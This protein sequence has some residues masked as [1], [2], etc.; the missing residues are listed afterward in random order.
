MPVSGGAAQAAN[1]GQIDAYIS[2]ILPD[3]SNLVYSTL[4]GGGDIEKSASIAVDAVGNAVVGG[5]TLSSNFPAV[6][7]FQN[8]LPGFQAGFVTKVNSTGTAF[9]FST[10]L[11]GRKAD[12]VNAVAVEPTT[13]NVYAGGWTTS[14]NFPTVVPVQGQKRGTKA[15]IQSS[16]DGGLTWSENDTGINTQSA[17][18]LAINRNTPTSL[19]ASAD[20]SNIYRSVN[21]GGTWA[22]TVT[23]GSCGQVTV[24]P[25]KANANLLYAFGSLCTSSSMVKSTDGGASWGSAGAAPGVISRAM[26]VSPNNDSTL[27]AVDINSAVRKGTNGGATWT[28][29]SFNLPVATIYSIAIDSTGPQANIYL[30]GT[31]VVYKMAENGT[32]WTPISLGIDPN[33]YI[34]VIRTDPAGNAYALAGGV[35]TTLYKL[36]AGTNTWVTVYSGF[37][38]TPKSMAIAPSNSNVMYVG[39]GANGLGALFATT[40]GGA[41][42]S[43]RPSDFDPADIQ[44]H[45]T[46]PNTVHVATSLYLRTDGFITKIAAAGGSPLL[47][48]T[49]FGSASGG[50]VADEQ[51]NGLVTPATAGLVYATGDTNRLGFPITVGKQL[52]AQTA[53]VAKLSD[54]TPACSLTFAPSEGFFYPGGGTVTVSIVAPSACN[55]TAVSNAPWVTFSGPA[56]GTGIGQVTLVVGANPGAER[57][58]TI[59]FAATGQTIPVIQAASGCTYA[60]GTVAPVAVG[61]GPISIPL[62]TGAGCSWR[63][64]PSVTWLTMTSPTGGTGPTTFQV[65]VAPNPNIKLR[66]GYIY[67]GSDFATVLQS[68]S[69]TFGLSPASAS[70]GAQLTESTI[71][72]TASGGTC[73]WSAMSLTD[74]LSITSGSAGVGNGTVA[75]AAEQNTTGS[76]RSGS[77]QIGDKFFPVTQGECAFYVSPVSAGAPGAG[78][79][80][81]I[82]ISARANCGWT[83]VSNDVWITINSGSAGTGNGTVTYTVTPNL[84]ASPRTGSIT[85]AGQTFTIVQAAAGC[86]YSIAG[87]PAQGTAIGGT[88][89]FVLTSVPG[90]TWT[91]SSS[92]S[93][94]TITSATAG[95]GGTTVN[96]SYPANSALTIRTATI[97]IMGAPYTLIQNGVRT[98][99][100]QVPTAT[101][102]DN[103][104]G[105]RIMRVGDS[106]TTSLGGSFASDTVSAHVPGTSDTWTAVRLAGGGLYTNFY[107]SGGA[108]TWIGIG[109]VFLG[110][111]SIT[112]A[113]DGTAWVV[114]RDIFK[115]IWIYKVDTALGA[116]PGIFLGGIVES[117]PSAIVGPDG[118]LHIVGRDSWDGVWVV[119]FDTK[120]NSV[121]GWTFLGGIISGNPVATLGADN[122]VY[123]AV[124]DKYAGMWLARTTGGTA[125]WWFGGGIT[126]SDPWISADS[127]G[128]VTVALLSTFSTP[129]YRNFT[130]GTATWQPFVNPGGV[131]N[132]LSL[133]T[134]GG[135]A[136]LFGANTF[137]IYWYRSTD[138]TFGQAG[139]S[140]LAAGNFG[141]APR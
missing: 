127:T 120:T 99:A 80:G 42:W 92:A 116:S 43:Q 106:V 62:T 53:F 1:A 85:V 12:G 126:N 45:P 24:V 138:A 35:N 74:W 67:V 134:V 136:Y 73:G 111:P 16:T 77:L 103:F 61:G 20:I 5:S 89:S 83:A 70:I 133:A 113:A 119:R 8:S 46:S 6:A 25:A 11:G 38:S 55:W 3:G 72:V 64:E 48:S 65:T 40:N 27:Y 51:V 4:L 104:G 124:H 68:G 108:S 90:C 50:E 115:G 129:A 117:D 131:L 13:N 140:S 37:G 132:K 96:Y 19:V 84:I 18:T 15:V 7:A 33:D 114:G 79:P 109:G 34:P 17:F 28:D 32:A 110:N 112:A 14:D 23:V 2:K 105:L 30:G 69:C 122:A 54:S 44:V 87:S 101:F 107:S 139:F 71:A 97:T 98:I 21:S 49:Y 58:T 123:V 88:G 121:I 91:A 41:T 31:G 60:L 81:S 95:S 118:V 135:D 10:Y 125:N 63:A 102:R 39:V 26:V 66:E 36:V 141:A 29:I 137:R 128:V 52:G 9:L 22:K 76:A 56:S 57:T 47:L 93:W 100:S 94:L 75:W 86:L 130:E 82:T 59:S 78:G